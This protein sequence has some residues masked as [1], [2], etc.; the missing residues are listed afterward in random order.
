MK[1]F[2]VRHASAVDRHFWEGEEIDR[3][4]DDI[5]KTQSQALIERFSHIEISSVLSSGAARCKQTIWPTS[6]KCKK[7]VQEVKALFEGS[8]MAAEEL[9]ATI[10]KKK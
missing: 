8:G 5:G 3:P 7:E 1:I 2:L 4:L 9:I 10:L 6:I